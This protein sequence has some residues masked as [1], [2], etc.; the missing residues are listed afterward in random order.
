MADQQVSAMHLLLMMQA[1]CSSNSANTSAAKCGTDK[2]PC[3]EPIFLRA[4]DSA[5]KCKQIATPIGHT[6]I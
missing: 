5:K 6:D 2:W 1:E 4:L 3:H